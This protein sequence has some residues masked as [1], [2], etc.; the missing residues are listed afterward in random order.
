MLILDLLAVFICVCKIKNS[1]P[2]C[3]E[4]SIVK[5]SAL[6]M[7]SLYVI[8][9]LA[10]ASLAVAQ[11]N[12]TALG[13]EAIQAHFKQAG[14]T[15]DLLP[16]FDPIAILNLEYDGVTGDVSP[17]QAL[18]KTRESKVLADCRHHDHHSVQRLRLPRSFR[19]LVQ[20]LA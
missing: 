12:N 16:S 15:P 2:T 4:F 11:A 7:F 6:A 8:V 9:S 18:T 10:C 3:T 13:I 17:G 19:L 20:I 5:Y 14:I 1:T